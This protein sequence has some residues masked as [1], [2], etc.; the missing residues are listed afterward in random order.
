MNF[1]DLFENNFKVVLP[2]IYLITALLFLLM[3]GVVFSTSLTYNLPIITR[4]IAWL[5]IQTLF[6]ALLLVLNN[7][8]DHLVIFHGTLVHDFFTSMVKVFY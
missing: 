7:P 1:I 6:I 3:Y 2:E 4:G 5:S 8:I